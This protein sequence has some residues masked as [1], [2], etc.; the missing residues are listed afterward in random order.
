[1]EGTDESV[2]ILFFRGILLS[3]LPAPRQ[4]CGHVLGFRLS[5][6]LLWTTSRLSCG[7]VGLLG[8]LVLLLLVPV[9]RLA[10]LHLAHLDYL[11]CSTC[12][13]LLVL[14]VRKPGADPDRLNKA[15]NQDG[16]DEEGQ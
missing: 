16:Q 12:Q 14:I 8:H 11:L 1:M 6:S 5:G 7:H 9:V 4:S 15:D 10:L 2:E 13:S 3:W